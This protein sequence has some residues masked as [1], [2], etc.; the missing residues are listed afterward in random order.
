MKIDKPADERNIA[1]DESA[2]EET[3]FDSDKSGECPKCFQQ[4]SRDRGTIVM[5][6]FFP[7]DVSMQTICK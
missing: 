7:N 3:Y 2:N 1:P 6:N 5:L 4:D